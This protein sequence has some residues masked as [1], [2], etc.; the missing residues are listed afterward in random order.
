MFMTTQRISFF[1][2]LAFTAVCIFSCKSD[3]EGLNSVEIPTP[4]PSAIYKDYEIFY[5]DSGLTQ[6]KIAGIT[7]EQFNSVNGSEAYDKMTD[8]VHLWFYDEDKNVQ[9]EL[10][11]DNAIRNRVTGYMEAFGNVVVFNEKGE[12]LNTE[13]L[14][15]DEAK[16]QI[17]SNDS[18]TIT[19][20]NQVITGLGLVSD[21]NFIDYEIKNV[22]SIFY[23]E[24]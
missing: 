15:W 6:A 3:S 5:S 17:I 13:H 21:Q 10:V 4:V 16:A 20:K 18:V 2:R 9:S 14:I 1:F 8:S 11:A 19:K 22:K 7:L 23:V 12:R 24:K